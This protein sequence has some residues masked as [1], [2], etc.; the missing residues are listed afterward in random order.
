MNLLILDK[1]PKISA[2]YHCDMHVKGFILN[3]SQLLSA[4]HWITLYNKVEEDI[5]FKKKKDFTEFLFKK[6]PVG[7]ENRPPYGTNYISNPCVEW[8]RESKENYLW[9]VNLIVCLGEEYYSRFGKYHKCSKDAIWFKQNI[10]DDIPEGCL[11]DFCINL[12]D[13][14]KI[15][16]DAVECYRYY[17]NNEKSEMAT[18]TNDKPHWF[19]Y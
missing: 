19:K 1:D 11:T 9:A 15:S 13:S 2:S 16:N 17:Y 14:C 12:I 4:V 7:H 5:I 18:W 8:I 6:Y 10:P 3:Y